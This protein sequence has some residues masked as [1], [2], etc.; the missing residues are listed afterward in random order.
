VAGAVA[1]ILRNLVAGAVASTPRSLW[2]CCSWYTA[3]FVVGAV[4]ST[5]HSLVVCAVASILLS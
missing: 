1:S 4:A 2:R 3:Q 5:V